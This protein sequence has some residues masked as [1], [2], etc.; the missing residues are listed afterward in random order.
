MKLSKEQRAYL[1]GIN[2]KKWRKHLKAQFKFQNLMEKSLGK[3]VTWYEFSAKEVED[4]FND[5]AK[6]Y[7]LDPDSPQPET[8]TSEKLKDI[9][10]P[11]KTI[12]LPKRE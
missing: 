5:L 1:K 9:T 6:I 8:L 12:G 2:K 4:K 10:N 7:M 3:G 11:K